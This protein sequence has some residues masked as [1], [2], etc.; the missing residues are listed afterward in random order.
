MHT[1]NALGTATALDTATALV[2]PTA[3]DMTAMVSMMNVP[4]FCLPSVCWGCQ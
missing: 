1:V 2:E 4:L 3:M